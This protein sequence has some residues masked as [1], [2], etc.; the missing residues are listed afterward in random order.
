MDPGGLNK[1]LVQAL[2]LYSIILRDIE[3]LEIH[4]HFFIGV[5]ASALSNLERI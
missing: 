4:L 1:Q 3:L 2:K 5:K